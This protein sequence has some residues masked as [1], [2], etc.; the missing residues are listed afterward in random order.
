MNK[1]AKVILILCAL[2]LGGVYA[3][4][5]QKGG[6]DNEV[7]TQFWTGSFAGGQILI[8]LDKIASVSKQKYILD[9]QFLIHEV[10]IDS[11]GN[12]LTRIYYIEPLAVSV[13]SNTGVGQNAINRAKDVT[14]GIQDRTGS[15]DLDPNTVVTKTYPGTTH[16][17][18]IEYR[19]GTVDE[20]DAAYKSISTALTRGRGRTYNSNK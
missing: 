10:A 7:P 2:P 20:L 9:G 19:V 16:S 3:Q 15:K 11:V 8:P 1:L 6:T 4:D 14:S 17:H 5:N 18:T 13:T 12:A